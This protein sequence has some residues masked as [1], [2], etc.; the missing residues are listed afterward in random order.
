MLFRSVWARFAA[1]VAPLKV[2]LTAKPVFFNGADTEF[3][4]YFFVPGIQRAG[5]WKTAMALTAEN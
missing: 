1:A 5:G 2:K 4:N 3:V